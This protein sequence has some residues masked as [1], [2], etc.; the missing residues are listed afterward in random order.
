MN[1]PG[2]ELYIWMLSEMQFYSIRIELISFCILV[3]EIRLFALT[4][5]NYL[6]SVVFSG[7]VN[8]E[9]KGDRSFGRTALH[10]EQGF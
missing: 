4:F 10:N 1:V 5:P 3:I 8:K 2:A 9:W 7:R 6:C